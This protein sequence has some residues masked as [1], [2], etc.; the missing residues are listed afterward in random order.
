MS[1]KEI[2]EQC[3]AKEGIGHTQLGLSVE[4][5]MR[6]CTYCDETKTWGCCDRGGPDYADM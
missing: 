3:T 6:G 1:D 5:C 2:S 4:E